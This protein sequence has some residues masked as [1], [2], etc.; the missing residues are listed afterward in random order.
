MDENEN[1]DVDLRPCP[2]CGEMPNLI[3]NVLRD[4]TLYFLECC[5]KDC[6]IRP[7][8]QHCFRNKKQAVE[9]WNS[10]G[11]EKSLKTLPAMT[12]LM[13]HVTNIAS[14]VV[15]LLQKKNANYGNSVATPPTLTPYIS[16]EEAI[17]IRL[18]D[19]I[20]RLRTLKA[21]EPDKV[22]ESIEDTIKDMIGY[23]LLLL[24]IKRLNTSV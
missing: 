16:P 21:G 19:K 2:W 10:W 12:N 3:E 6:H 22:G 8:S 11:Q 20:A 17:F 15:A 13:M 1:F 5:N 4:G 24:A 18:S 9:I 14:E 7:S 23:E